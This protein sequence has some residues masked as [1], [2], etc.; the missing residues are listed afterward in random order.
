[1]SAATNGAT[2]DGTGNG[3]IP[4]SP[5]APVQVKAGRHREASS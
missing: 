3:A 1:M 5:D 2:D 4:V